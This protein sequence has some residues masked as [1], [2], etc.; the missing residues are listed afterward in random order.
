M[1]DG[2]EER[3]V[4]GAD[5]LTPL[6]DTH[7]RPRTYCEGLVPRPGGDNSGASLPGGQFRTGRPGSGSLT[8]H[9][10]QNNEGSLW[11]SWTIGGALPA[12]AGCYRVCFPRV[13]ITPVSVN[14]THGCSSLPPPLAGWGAEHRIRADQDK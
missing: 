13:V 2:D 3:F 9:Q 11:P 1:G 6:R 4:R 5:R 7:R 14:A 10:S 12:Y 8:V